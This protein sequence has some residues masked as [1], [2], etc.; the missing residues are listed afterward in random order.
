M[1]AKIQARNLTVSDRFRDYVADR[2]HKIEALTHK[3]EAF[4]IK[5]TRH[6]HSRTSGPEDTVELTVVEPGHVVRAE[7]HAG[8]KFAAFD[9]AFDKLTE[10]LR[11]A[12]DRRKV[13]H[14]RHAALGTAELTASDFATLDVH[15]VD[16]EVL[17]GRAAP[18][19]ENEGELTE[20]TS[21][22]E[23][24][25]KE[26]TAEPMTV[27]DAIDRMELVGHDFYLFLDSA[28]AK[29]SVVYRRKGWNYGVLT[30]G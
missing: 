3:L 24:R 22:I 4:E 13:H 14:G 19:A 27:S 15:A 16:G 9:V 2:T 20:P 10:R 21:P 5:V 1:E 12:A 30:L 29:T 18:A 25:R 28:T 7:A 6:D 8:D 26:F 11:R 23:I 17:L